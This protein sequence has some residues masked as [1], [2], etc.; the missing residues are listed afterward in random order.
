MHNWWG[1]SI[2][3][4]WNDSFLIKW[5]RFRRHITHNG[6][7][8]KKSITVSD[9][10]SMLKTYN[11]IFHVQLK[12][13]Q[14]IWTSEKWIKICLSLLK[15]LDLFTHFDVVCVFAKSNSRIYHAFM[16]WVSCVSG[17]VVSMD[18]Y[19][20]CVASF[21]FNWLVWESS[22]KFGLF[23]LFDWQNVITWNKE[24]KK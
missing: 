8:D 16:L 10:R 6:R 13:K 20:S 17:G 12:I 7:R 4:C 24:D 2:F 21:F 1:A 19:E 5:H 18:R 22:K 11:S 3:C 15:I 14:N 9:V 23:R